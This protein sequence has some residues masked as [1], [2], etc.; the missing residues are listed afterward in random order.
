[1]KSKSRIA[2]VGLPRQ[3][4]VNVIPYRTCMVR[5]VTTHIQTAYHVVSQSAY[6][7]FYQ[8]LRRTVPNYEN[9]MCLVL[10]NLAIRNNW[11]MNISYFDLKVS[12]RNGEVL[13][14]IIL[15]FYVCLFKF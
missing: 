10:C 11:S 13:L 8:K 4:V 2:N 7:T 14:D 9:R 12:A 1:M 15:Q 3:Q 5:Y 6:R